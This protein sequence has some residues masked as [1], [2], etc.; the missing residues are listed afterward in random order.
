MAAVDSPLFAI[1]T[2]FVLLRCMC[3]LLSQLL[4]RTDRTVLLLFS[5]EHNFSAWTPDVLYRKFATSSEVLAR[6]FLS[7]RAY[8]VSQEELH[9]SQKKRNCR[10]LAS[11]VLNL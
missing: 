8:E 4:K 5:R 10:T 3:Y 2:V 1:E 7:R 6:D 9:D 11:P